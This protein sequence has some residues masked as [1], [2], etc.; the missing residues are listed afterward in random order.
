VLPPAPACNSRRYR[1][2][3]GQDNLR[4]HRPVTSA[5]RIVAPIWSLSRGAGLR[6][7]AADAADGADAK[8]RLSEFTRLM[9]I[10]WSAR[11]RLWRHK[12]EVVSAGRGACP[13]GLVSS[14]SMPWPT[15]QT[16]L[17]LVRVGALRLMIRV[18][19]RPSR[20]KLISIPSARRGVCA[21]R[22]RPASARGDFGHPPPVPDASSLEG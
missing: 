7:T 18:P 11:Q 16:V 9:P 4:R 17:T 13:S 5:T 14:Q 15:V 1:G 22:S 12:D 3:P 8:C 20:A 19:A 21:R 2:T 10:Y 6:H